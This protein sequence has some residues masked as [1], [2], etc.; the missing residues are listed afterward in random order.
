MSKS[1]YFLGSLVYNILSCKT[2]DYY[3]K[4]AK[5]E[6]EYQCSKRFYVGYSDVDSKDRCKLS[7][8]L[9]LCQNVATI[10]SDGLGYGTKGMM[11]RNLAWL[12]TS[13]RVRIL[14]YPIADREV[15]CRTW[16]RGLK[17]VLAQRDYEILD[18]DGTPMILADSQWALF[19]LGE[20]KLTRVTEE[21]QNAYGILE[22]GVFEGEGKKH[23][24]DNDVI[25][26]EKEFEIG[27]RDIDTNHH[28]NN[29]RYFDYIIE[30][31]PDDYE[32]HEF[33][34]VY[35]KQIKYK[36]RIVVSYGSGY[37]RIK[38]EAGETCFLVRFN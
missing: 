12:V 34:C 30:V 2:L 5:F 36:D 28:L 10:H 17:G 38:N 8:I 25:E 26:I 9:D 3:K 4:E 11:E 15:E 35:K 37:A 6:V 21:M 13:M 14:H 16:S 1:I 32:V 23:I 27:K 19:D 31:L 29:A 33:E 18:L 22:R 24:R 20:Q 7:R